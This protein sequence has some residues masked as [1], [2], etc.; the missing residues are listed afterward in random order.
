MPK[1]H[2]Q[3]IPATRFE[4]AGLGQPVDGSL[5]KVAASSAGRDNVS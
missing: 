2:L 1:W 3:D 4:P 5:G